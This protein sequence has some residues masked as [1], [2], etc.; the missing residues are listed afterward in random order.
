MRC[1]DSAPHILLPHHPFSTASSFSVKLDQEQPTADASDPFALS[2]LLAA[3]TL[4]VAVNDVP[5]TGP[6]T[7]RS[8]AWHFLPARDLANRTEDAIFRGLAFLTDHLFLRA[9]CRLGASGRTLFIRVYLIPYDLENVRGQLHF[10]H[11]TVV[12]E[13]RRHL[14]GIL[15]LIV[16]STTLWDADEASFAAQPTFFLSMDI[17]RA[18]Q[19]LSSAGIDPC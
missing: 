2:N 6:G 18:D 9:T 10:R 11:E 13:A 7:S 14:H 12:T 16:Q 15:P 17:V 19:V 3:G 8:D 5:C 1:N 4:T